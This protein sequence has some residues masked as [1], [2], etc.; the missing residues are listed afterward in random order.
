ME[1]SPSWEANWFS[2]SQ[3][4]PRILGNPYVHYHTHKCPPPVPIL[5]QL[6]PVHTPT[7]YFLKIH[8][9]IILPSTPGSPKWSLS[10]RFPQHN[11]VYASLSH[12]RYMPSPSNSSRF[13]TQTVLREEY[14]SFSSSIWSFLQ[15][16]VD[17]KYSK[18]RVIAER[19]SQRT[20]P[21]FITFIIS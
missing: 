7:P 10:L 12:T 2:A 9:N 20:F 5:S 14:R 3:K 4:I 11:P 17:H 16:S 1:Q 8:L 21:N 13:S 18:R 6:D 19:T 15:S